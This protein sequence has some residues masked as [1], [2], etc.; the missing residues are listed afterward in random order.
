MFVILKGILI[1]YRG[2]IPDEIDLLITR[3]SFGVGAFAIILLA[4][5]IL[6]KTGNRRVI[7]VLRW[8]HLSIPF[9]NKSAW[10]YFVFI[11][12]ASL[13]TARI[14]EEIRNRIGRSLPL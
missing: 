4:P 1:Y 10:T 11:P 14:Y 6:D 5:V 9:G 2:M 3:G 12:P 13:L 7:G 8:I